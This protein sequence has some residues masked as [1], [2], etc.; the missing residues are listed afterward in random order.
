VLC[1]P[2][3]VLHDS[4]RHCALGCVIYDDFLQIESFTNENMFILG[5]DFQTTK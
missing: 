1:N 2:T 3:P 4:K 5:I